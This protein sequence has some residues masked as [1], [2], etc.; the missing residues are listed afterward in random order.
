MD[1]RSLFNERVSRAFALLAII[2]SALIIIKWKEYEADVLSQIRETPQDSIFTTNEPSPEMLS[3][4]SLLEKMAIKERK[5]IKVMVEHDNSPLT[6]TYPMILDA[7]K[8]FDPDIGDN[9]QF[10][11]KQIEGPIVELKPNV[12]SSKVSFEGNAGE[13]TFE[14]K[15]SDDY[16]SE[17][18]I[19]KTV[20]IEPEPN[21]PPV[22]DFSVRQ[23]SELN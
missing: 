2:I 3:R 16:G 4:I 15:V 1:K 19:T 17:S 20:V 22:I 8:S 12:F 10:V 5:K 11:W 7:T 18:I 13:Y 14:L 21:S 6:S 9:L 23:G